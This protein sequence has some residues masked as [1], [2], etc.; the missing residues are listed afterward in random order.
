MLLLMILDGFGLAL[1]G[2]GNA[3][4]LARKPNLFKLFKEH[5][6]TQIGASGISVG[7]PEE[8]MGNSEVGHL[9]IGAG[10]VVHQEISRINK[11]I[12]TGEFFDNV[13]LKDRLVRVAA[14]NKN[15]HLF[16]LLSDGGVHSSLEHLAAIVEFCH[17]EEVQNL[18]LH[19]FMDGRDTSPTSGK[20][21]MA[22]QVAA[23]ARAGVGEVATVM[24][25]YWGMDRDHRWERIEKAFQA[26]VDR[27]GKSV[28]DPVAAIQESYDGDVT[29]EFIEPLIV[30]TRKS[31]EF[32]QGD[33]CLFFNFR[34]DRVRQLSGILAGQTDSAHPHPELPKLDVISLTQYD[35]KV[36]LPIIFPPQKLDD[37]LVKVLSE[38]GKRFLKIAETEKYAHVTYF[39]N[40]GEE[41]VYEGEE[42]VLI[43]SPKVATYDLQPEM[44]APE[45]ASR[46]AAL[47]RK[48]YLD[49]VILNFANPDMVGH[50]GVI[51]AAVKAIEAVDAGVGEVMAAVE[52]VG[53][54]AL[55]T[56]D[57]GNAEQMIDPVT[58]KPFTA[59]TTNP[60]PLL[61][62]DKKS[63]P[64]LPP[65]GVLANIAPTMLKLLDL[66]APPAMTGQSLI[67][68]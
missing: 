19:A 57:H 62:Y 17:R 55:I 40:G 42:R 61:L 49:V 41:V 28:S 14:E 26:I 46:C 16:G 65:G 7:L 15:V 37:I 33:L 45:V 59:H 67:R 64:H 32:D 58:G 27:Q 10:R 30:E 22:D 52:E 38:S 3:I 68:K 60:V 8:Q 20:G 25:R 35:E 23:F 29:D 9:N 11:A 24:G 34:A 51:P 44:S 43:E 36:P 6:H 47:I 56:S 50:T 18:F 66:K 13:V 31:V 39:F 5:P 21:F 1:P 48:N 53:G 63:K 4:S 54:R 2:P 12:R